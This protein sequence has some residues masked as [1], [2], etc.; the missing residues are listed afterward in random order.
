MAL[1]TALKSVYTGETESLKNL[2]VVMTQA[3]LEEFARSKGLRKKIKDMTEAE[4]VE[5]RYAYVMAKTTNAQGD[6]LRTGGNAANQMRMHSEMLKE[7]QTNWGMVILPEYTKLLSKANQLLVDNMPVIQKTF[8]DFYNVL[9]NCY[10]M[11][12][13][14]YNIF[15]TYDDS[16][17]YYGGKESKAIYNFSR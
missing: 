12:T 2:G 8:E 9:K 11:F 1:T 4:K 5:L 15:R 17:L 13:G 10:H 14:L 3:N 16:F 6:F 7:I